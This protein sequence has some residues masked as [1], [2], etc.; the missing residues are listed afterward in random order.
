[1][2]LAFHEYKILKDLYRFIRRYVPPYKRYL[3]LSVVA[4]IISAIL[5]LVAF[6][7]VMPIL[8]ILFQ[9]DERAK[10]LMDFADISFLNVRD[11]SRAADI[12]NNNFSYYIGQ[13]A[14]SHGIPYTLML[15]SVYLVVMTGFKV[16]SAYLAL[17]AMIPI[18]TGIVRD[19]RVALYDKLLALPL[20]YFSSERKGDVLARIS[21]DVAEVENSIMSSLDLV[22]KNPIMIVVYLGSMILISWKLTLL[23]LIHI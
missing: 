13:L 9:I 5:N 16:G 10:G 18:R 3:L 23:S 2:A 8:R 7:L 14:E 1:M 4:N 17:Y 6:A 20:G 12:L 21:G 19:M 22:L 11:W 15:L